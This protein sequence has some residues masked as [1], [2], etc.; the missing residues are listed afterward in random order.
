MD[1]E[2]RSVTEK[3]LRAL[4]RSDPARGEKAVFDEY[5]SYVYA[6]AFRQLN[7]KRRPVIHFRID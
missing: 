2:V 4:L 6:M 7:G 1:L 5:Y 3:Q